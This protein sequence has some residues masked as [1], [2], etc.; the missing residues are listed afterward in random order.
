MSGNGT[1]NFNGIGTDCTGSCKSNYHMITTAMA[2]IFE[3]FESNLIMLFLFFSFT[4][5]HRT[6]VIKNSLN[7]TWRPF[8]I[9]V[10]TLCNGDHV[11]YR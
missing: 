6:E 1:H 9:P 7:P 8:T 5:V 2:D 11:R 4:V 10:K 3:K